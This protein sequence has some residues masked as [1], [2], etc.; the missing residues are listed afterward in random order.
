MYIG[1]IENMDF[2]ILNKLKKAA[3][4]YMVSCDREKSI[5]KPNC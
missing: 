5:D 3:M 4:M 1:E 2:T